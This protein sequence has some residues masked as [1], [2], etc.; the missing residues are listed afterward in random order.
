MVV[1]EE[2]NDILDNDQ[3]QIYKQK[4]IR[5]KETLNDI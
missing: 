5:R 2:Y 3:L 1:G 4:G